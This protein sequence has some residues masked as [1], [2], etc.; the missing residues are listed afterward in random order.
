MDIKPQRHLP[1]KQLAITEEQ[2]QTILTCC[3][4]PMERL[5]I[6]MLSGTGLRASEFCA[7]RMKDINLEKGY[8]VV[9]RGKGGKRRRVGMSDK[10]S[11]MLK[12]YVEKTRPA[13]QDYVFKSRFREKMT[14][15]EHWRALKSHLTL[16]VEPL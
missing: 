10:V 16:C 9:E 7:L 15:S 4:K 5:I 2:L 8:L 3:T 13:S 14:R 12:E 1:P 11:T 6:T